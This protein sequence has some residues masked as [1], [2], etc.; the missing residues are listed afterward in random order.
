[1]N[2]IHHASTQ[3]DSSAGLDQNSRTDRIIAL[4]C[5]SPANVK[6]A[7]TILL[8]VFSAAA[9]APIIAPYSQTQTFDAVL[10]PWSSQF[11]LG[12]DQLG[13]D[14][15]SRLLFGGRN[16]ILIA[17]ATT[18][19]SFSVGA[20]AGSLS[21]IRGGWTD[22]IMSRV[23]DILM[24][25]PTLIFAL[26]LL[27][28]FGT[29]VLNLV[30]IIAFLD[31]TRVYRLTRAVSVNVVA[32]EFVEV[33]RLRGEGWIWVMRREIL[34][35][36]IPTLVAEFGIRFCYVFLT[37]AALSFLGVGIQPPTADWGSMVRENAS[38]VG[39][40]DS[41]PMLALTPLIPAF[42]IGMVT[43]S[44]NLIIDWTLQLVGGLKETR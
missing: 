35:N 7:T 5:S 10:A 14:V 31:A 29:N 37:V 20:T 36:I 21:A 34:P 24:A 3:P 27:S 25:I 19:L 1:M 18:T 4:M 6:I 2:T 28:V 33:A 43:I 15:F 17:V 13:R 40:L 9:L 30:L 26:M 44:M 23:N 16:S 42:A 11:W 12:T 38:L 32:M 41:D 39:F 22:Q 8:L